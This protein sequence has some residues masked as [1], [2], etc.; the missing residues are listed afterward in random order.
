MIP[1]CLVIFTELKTKIAMNFNN[2][3]KNWNMA[4]K[5][6]TP[7]TAKT[8]VKRVTEKPAAVKTAITTTAKPEITEEDIRNKA[9]E[10]FFAR[11]NSGEAG[12]HLSDWLAAEKALKGKK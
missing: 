11:I 9:E 4:T 3:I 7:A 5:K 12:D 6:V 10:I 1:W 2:N 8:P